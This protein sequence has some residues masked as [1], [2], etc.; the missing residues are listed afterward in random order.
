MSLEIQCEYLFVTK[1]LLDHIRLSSP[2]NYCIYLV[3]ISIEY[4]QDKSIYE[5]NLAHK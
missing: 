2:I 1:R 5:C 4:R 3:V